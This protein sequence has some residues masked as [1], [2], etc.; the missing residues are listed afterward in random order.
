MISCKK[1]LKVMVLEPFYRNI[2]FIGTICA[3]I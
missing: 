3:T 1:A 2:Y